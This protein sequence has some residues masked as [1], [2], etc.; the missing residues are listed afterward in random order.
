MYLQ[1]T[2]DDIQKS[3]G[4]GPTRSYYN[5]AYSS[6][7]AYMLMYRQIDP[8]RNTLPMQV[9]DFPKHIQELLAKMKDERK[10]LLQIIEKVIDE[11][12]G[13][14]CYM[15]RTGYVSKK[16]GRPLW[17]TAF[18][19]HPTLKK[20]VSARIPAGPETTLAE[21]TKEFYSIFS[22]ENVVSLEQCH[23]TNYDRINDRVICSYEGKERETCRSLFS[24][25][26]IT[27]L[28][29]MCDKDKKFESYKEGNV[30]YL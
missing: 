18:C 23:L 16:Y 1:I 17:V 5:G 22:L 26:D 20:Q 4:G 28:L 27:L 19:N 10:E 14:R 6:T 7:N 30:Y 25:R 12:Y 9:E 8:E 29:E 21:I 11:R 13:D 2:Q 3:Y 15:K 24:E